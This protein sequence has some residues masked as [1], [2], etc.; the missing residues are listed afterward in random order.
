MNSG[1][2]YVL[3]V[4]EDSDGE[5]LDSFL[6]EELSPSRSRLKKLISKGFCTLNGV[7]VTK[8]SQTLLEHDRVSMTIPGTAEI[9]IEPQEMSL[10]VTYEDSALAVINKPAGMVVHPS[11]GHPGDTLVNALLHRYTELPAGDEA[12]RPGI[13]H[14]I[15]RDT[16]GLIVIARTSQALA[17]LKEQFRKHTIEREYLGLAVRVG[18]PGLKDEGDTVVTSHGR[19]PYNRM[20]FTGNEGTREAVTHYEVLETFNHGAALVRCQLETGRTH[21]IR[22]HLG[23]LGAPLLGD[24]LYGGGS[25]GSTGIIKRVAL[26]AAVLGFVHPTTNLAMRFEAPLPE[27]FELALDRL[28]SGDGW[29]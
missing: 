25:V 8:P 11:K 24:A 27:D 17:H 19:H 7:S 13:A 29:I 20:R 18:S 28:R 15:D 22:M 10:E 23:E 21:Q 9:S 2:T 12:R 1:E 14:R 16:S 3:H 26:H 6:A 4:D 5:R